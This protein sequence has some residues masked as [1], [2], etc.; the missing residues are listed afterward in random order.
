MLQQT[1]AG[2]VVPYFERFLARFPNIQ[3]LAR[4]SE[5]EVLAAW[6]GLG[7][8]GRA[9][10]LHRAARLI[11]ARGRFPRDYAT[12]RE[13]PGIG[14]YTAA[15]VASIAF[16]LPHATVDGNVRRVLSRLT[17]SSEG[18][19]EA[20]SKLLDREDPG[21]YNQALMELGAMICLPGDPRCG[22]CPVAG[23]CG[24]RRQGRVKDFPIRRRRPAPVRVAKTLL[25]VEKR[26]KLLLRETAFGS[27]PRQGICRRRP[28]ARSWGGSAIRS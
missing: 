7:Y 12:I 27:C 15:A 13:L 10:N 20:A 3:A 5:Q 24:A 9:R 21:R 28:P 1:R 23:L 22:T 2:V 19:A 8:Y 4:A 25:V 16:G 14:E 6:S 18:L 26:G 17:C 11:A